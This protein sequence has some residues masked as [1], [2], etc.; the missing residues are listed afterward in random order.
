MLYK[1]KHLVDE[2]FKTLDEHSV[3]PY[4][5]SKKLMDLAKK[6]IEVDLR[7]D[8]DFDFVGY[9][10]THCNPEAEKT[11]PLIENVPYKISIKVKGSLIFKGT[12]YAHTYCEIYWHPSQYGGWDIDTG[13][14]EMDEYNYIKDEQ[15]NI[16]DIKDY[17]KNISDVSLRNVYRTCIEGIIN[18]TIADFYNHWE[19]YTKY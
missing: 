9:A 16:V 4:P 10:E 13:E 2:F 11:C 6:Y 18:D 8:P 5:K 3:R 7:N 12:V 1:E 19:N 15:E 17:A 14:S